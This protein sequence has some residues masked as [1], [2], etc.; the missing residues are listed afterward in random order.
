MDQG[1]Y[2]Q[3]CPVAMASEIFCTRWTALVLR[4]L[5]SGSKRFNDLRRGVPTMSP[6]LLS[7]RL[8]ELEAAGIIMRSAKG[9]DYELTQAGEDLRPVIMA[10][11]EWG[12]AWIQSNLS[13]KN[14]D[15][16]LLMWD[17]RRRLN[18]DPLPRQRCTV[19]FRYPELS[20]GKQNWWLMIEDGEVDL[21]LTD[22]GHEVNLYVTGSL[23]AMTS[24]WMGLTTLTKEMET[25]ALEVLGDKEIASSMQVWLGLSP[26]AAVKR[27]TA[28]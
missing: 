20:A 5:L 14:L 1:S 7:K 2:G 12:Q 24:V 3:F 16:S 26:F 27:K 23:R 8:V 6:T 28:A 9:S 17:M 18:P 21:C 11:G 19:R 25:G 22:P 4:E 13:L 15:P 10:L